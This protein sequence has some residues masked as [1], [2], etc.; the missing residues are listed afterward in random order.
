MKT[1]TSP[2]AESALYIVTGATGSIGTSIATRLAANGKPLCLA[3]RNVEK[4]QALA[5]KIISATGNNDIHVEELDLSTFASV[6]AFVKR[7]QEAGRPVAALINNA[8]VMMRHEEYSVDGYEMTT[9]VNFLST[10]L[11]SMLMAPLIQ[12]GGHI[13]MT[14]SVTRKVASLGEE[15]P[16]TENFSQLGS[17]GRSKLAITLFAIYLAT[18]LKQRHINVECADPGVVN[19]EMLTMQRWFDPLANVLFR[20]FASSPQ[21]GATS[22]LNA[23]KS[24]DTGLL[25][26]H[27]TITTTVHELKSKE[28]FVT[29]LNN[30]LRILNPQ[31]TDKE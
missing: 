25:F 9:Q 28:T 16:A 11:L 12:E 31:K 20:P 5:D 8:G 29:L 10:A 4:A 30:T 7:M 24:A 2:A 19:S 17:Y 23:L 26:Y 6:R 18:V 14:T 13:V 27:D 1:S 15:Y 21:R 3:C 22:A